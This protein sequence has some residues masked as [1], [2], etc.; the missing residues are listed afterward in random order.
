MLVATLDAFHLSTTER[1]FISVTWSGQICDSIDVYL[2]LF[3]KLVV[4]FV[5]VHDLNQ[6]YV[7][8]ESISTPTLFHSIQHPSKWLE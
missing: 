6:L 4:L 5:M 1:G 2:P 7:T 3:V 8:D